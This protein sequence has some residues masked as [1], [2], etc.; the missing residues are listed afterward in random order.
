M[1]VDVG[2]LLLDN[3]IQRPLGDVGNAD[4]FEFPVAYRVVPGAETSLVVERAAEGLLSDARAMARQLVDTGA[5][6]I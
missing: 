4:T 2:I 5:R 6:A 3:H 1:T